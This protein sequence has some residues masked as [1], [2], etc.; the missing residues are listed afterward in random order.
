[1]LTTLMDRVLMDIILSYRTFRSNRLAKK[2]V[3]LTCVEAFCCTLHPSKFSWSTEFSWFLSLPPNTT[4]FSKTT[5]TNSFFYRSLQ[6]IMKIY[7][8]HCH[9]RWKKAIGTDNKAGCRSPSSSTSTSTW[10][11]LMHRFKKGCGIANFTLF[12]LWDANYYTLHILLLLW[13]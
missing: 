10:R 7:D 5:P 12:S 11:L 3:I 13:V 9:L 1:M 2:Q 6:I 4:T 8:D